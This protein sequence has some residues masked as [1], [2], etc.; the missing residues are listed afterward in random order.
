MTSPFRWVATAILFLFVG[1]I[2]FLL[3]ADFIYADIP[4]MKEA[5]A[6][7]HLRRAALLSLGTSFAAALLATAVAVPAGYALSRYPLPGKMF[8][9]TLIDASIVLPPLVA[10]ISLLVAFRLSADL[11]T[12][13]FVVLRVVG[14]VAA[15]LADR[16]IYQPAGIVL[17]QFFICAGYALRTIK[18]AFDSTDPRLELVAE[19][20]GCTQFGAFWRAA[21]P[22]AGPG[23]A[24][25][26]VLSW[27]RAFGVFGPIMIVAGA[28]RGR[29]EVLPTAIYLEIS[30]GRLEMALAISLF[31]IL[32]SFAVL[33]VF[34]MFVRT[35]V[36]GAV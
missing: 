10:G 7:P 34:R 32:V 23:I 16:M 15:W 27:A 25:G 6:A 35:S 8:F 9:D 19:T 33:A 20:L 3:L 1:A 31:M 29:T 22:A 14:I 5:F 17:A 18:A 2:L 24:A 36:F 4:S 13:Q 12:S 28:V 30:I 11:Q 26:A 21:V